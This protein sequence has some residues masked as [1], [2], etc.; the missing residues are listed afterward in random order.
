MQQ[1]TS[2]QVE[3]WA[4]TARAG[5]TPQQL[6]Q[7]VQLRIW[8]GSWAAWTGPS[9]ARLRTLLRMD[10]STIV[11]NVSQLVKLPASRAVVVL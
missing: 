6:A 9:A 10:G 2:R 1:T 4:G 5:A 3:L 7:L 8:P 11:L